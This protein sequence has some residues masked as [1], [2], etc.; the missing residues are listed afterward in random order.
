MYSFMLL[1]SEEPFG[2]MP[3]LLAARND[4]FMGMGHDAKQRTD[5]EVATRNTMEKI[6]GGLR[7]EFVNLPETLMIRP[8]LFS[9]FKTAAS[10]NARQCANRAAKHLLRETVETVL[11]FLTEHPGEIIAQG[12][13]DKRGNLLFKLNSSYL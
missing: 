6:R 4:V 11:D 2:S 12:A 8:T 1:Q 7:G 9:V 3:G 5:F 10:D 13:R